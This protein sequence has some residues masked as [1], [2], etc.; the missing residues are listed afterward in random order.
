MKRL[1]ALFILGGTLSANAQLFDNDVRTTLVRSGVGYIYNMQPDSA[2]LYI[3]TLESIMPQ[4]PVIPLMKAMTV[5]WVAMPNVTEDSTFSI[6]TGYLYETIRMSERIDGGRQEHPEA[7]FFEITARGL[8]AEYYA[9]ADYYMKALTE[10]GKAYNLLRQVFQLTK[11]NPEF[12][13]PAGVY[14][15]FR[16]MYPEKHPSYKPLLWFFRSGDAK[17]GISQIK[18]A[19]RSAVLTKVEA[20]IYLSYIYLRYEEIP[21]LAQS[22]L[23][24]L[25]NMY[26]NNDYV[27]AKYL[28]SLDGGGDFDSAPLAMI[29]QLIEVD[30]PYYKSAGYMFMGLYEEKVNMDAEKA[31]IHYKKSLSLLVNQDKKPDYYTSLIHLGMSRIF[32]EQKDVDKAIYHANES[33]SYAEIKETKQEAKAILYRLE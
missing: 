31:L 1:I 10:A 8:L 16:E 18:E 3:D 23:L 9:D 20:Y 21:E 28:E 11:E 29:E 26:P 5:L 33:I 6:F 24:E 4:H 17:L 7:I 13:L 25:S 27:V 22:Y 12:Y 30:K 15:Y 2:K 32:M 19:C 14:N